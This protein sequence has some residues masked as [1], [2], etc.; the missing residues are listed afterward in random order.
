MPGFWDFWPRVSSLISRIFELV[1][2]SQRRTYALIQKGIFVLMEI[3][4]AISVKVC[5][6]LSP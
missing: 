1:A 3:N 2:A 4:S 6:D 5:L